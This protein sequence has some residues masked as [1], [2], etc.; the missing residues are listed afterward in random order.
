MPQIPRRVVEIAQQLK[1][2]EKPRRWKVKTMMKWFDAERRRENVS[3]YP[4][5]AE[6]AAVG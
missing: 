1:Q 2:G 4:G 6:G 3:V 5:A